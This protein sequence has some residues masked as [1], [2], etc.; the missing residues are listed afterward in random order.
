MCAL[1]PCEKKKIVP[2]LSC[3]MQGLCSLVTAIWTL[4]GNMWDLVPWP[5]IEPEPS[6][7]G[8]WSLSHWTPREVLTTVFFF[9]FFKLNFWGQS[10]RVQWSGLFGVGWL[11][12]GSPGDG[13]LGLRQQWATSLPSQP[14]V[15]WET[16]EFGGLLRTSPLRPQAEI[17]QPTWGNG[18]RPLWPSGCTPVAVWLSVMLKRSAC[19]ARVLFSF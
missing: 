18:G 12:S 7:F 16:S 6:A 13:A 5:G 3:D 8:A 14:F 4:N 2:G 9:F 19:T 10:A 11:E 15:H 17:A 1:P